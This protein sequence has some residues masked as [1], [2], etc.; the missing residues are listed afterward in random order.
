[1][2]AT[3][4]KP[5]SILQEYIGCHLGG[6]HSGGPWQRDVFFGRPRTRQTQTEKIDAV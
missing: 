2:W 4:L 1:V 6:P 5:R 3:Q